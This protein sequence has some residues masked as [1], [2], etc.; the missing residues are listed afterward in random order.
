MLKCLFIWRSETLLHNGRMNV[1][2][3]KN[4]TWPGLLAKLLVCVAGMLLT[5]V[6]ASPSEHDH[7]RAE[8]AVQAGQ[9]LP[10]QNVLQKLQTDYPGQVLEVELE[11]DDGRWI[12]EIKLL[13]AGG[14]LRKLKLNAQTGEVLQSK[15]KN[16]K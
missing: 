4:L 10:L 3:A 7:D 11:H 8:R 5:G 1:S 12:Y 13:Q 16:Q 2:F 9:A 14:Q 15:L 6:W